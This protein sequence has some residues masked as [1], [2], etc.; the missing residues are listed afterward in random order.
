MQRCGAQPQWHSLTG[1]RGW[2]PRLPSHGSLA[3]RGSTSSSLWAWSIRNLL[4]GRNY[5]V[6]LRL[7]LRQVIN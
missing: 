2:Q 6:V 1:D 7:L 5:L 4:H 3:G